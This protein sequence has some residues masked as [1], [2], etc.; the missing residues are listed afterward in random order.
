MYKIGDNILQL[1][2]GIFIRLSII[3]EKT[4]SE[5]QIEW[6]DK[7]EHVKDKLNG[8]NSTKPLL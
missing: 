8:A 2:K 7:G 6:L 3:I 1:S 5:Y 4:E